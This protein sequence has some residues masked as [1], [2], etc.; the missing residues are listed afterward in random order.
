MLL[1]VTK[2][3]P[4]WSELPFPVQ[5]SQLTSSSFL[6]VVHGV[7]KL[8]SGAVLLLLEYFVFENGRNAAA[9]DCCREAK[10][11][12]ATCETPVLVTALAVG[13]SGGPSPF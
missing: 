4:I 8:I 3:L 6:H 13:G 1:F 10:S 7:R 12:I 2:I 9:S 5:G 11:V